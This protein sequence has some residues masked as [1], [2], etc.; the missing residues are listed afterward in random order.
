MRTRYAVAT[1]LVIFGYIIVAAYKL[2]MVHERPL[3]VMGNKPL[4]P[5]CN[6]VE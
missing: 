4:S 2:G 1:Y 3:V 6:D 5:L